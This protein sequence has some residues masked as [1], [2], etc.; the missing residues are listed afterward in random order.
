MEYSLVLSIILYICGCFYMLFGAVLIAANPKS[1][2]NKLFLLLSSSLAIWSFSLSIST[3]APTEEVSAFWRSFSVFGWGMFSSILLHFVLVLTKLK[4]RISK[5]RVH[6]MLYVPAFINIILFGPFGVL[7]DRQYKMVKTA[8]G[9][10]NLAPNYAA[11]IW[12]NAYYI[13][14]SIT[15]LVLLGRWWISIESHTPE[16][17]QATKFL[18]TI[19][20]FFFVEAVVDFLPDI[21]DKQ[22]FPKIPVLFFIIPTIMLFIVLK[23]FG[24]LSKTTRK[25][26][27]FPK[28]K[29]NLAGDRTRLFHTST[30]I[31]LL[32]S[33]ISFLVGYFGQG[34]SLERELLIA[35]ILI[36]FGLVS[37]FIPSI[38]SNQAVQNVIFLVICASGTFY[39]MLVNA[40][41]G[42][43]T[44]WSVYILFLLFTVTLD[45]R[46]LAIIFTA[47]CVVIQ[48]AFWIFYPKIS[49]T[50]DGNEYATRI[51]IIMLSYVAVRYLTNEYNSKV[52]DYKRFAS[53]Q[54]VLER[55]SSSLISISLDN[56]KEKIDELLEMADEILEFSHAYVIEFGTDDEYA[57][58]FS[59]CAKGAESESFPFYSGLKVKTATLPMAAPLIDQDTP[60]M[61]EDISRVSEEEDQGL[62]EFFMPRG[63]LSY[64]AL[65]VNVNSKTAGILVVEY[66]DQLDIE[67]AETRLYFLRFIVN[68]LADA[69]KKTMYEE[70]LYNYA[71]FDETT[72]LANRSMLK[73]QLDQIIHD[74]EGLEKTAILDIE[75]ENLRVIK[76]T[77]GQST[78]EQIMIKSAQVLE[79]LLEGR[80]LLARSGEGGFTIVLPSV[81]STEQV[82]EYAKNVLDSF[83]Q[84]IST[85]TDIE[86]LFVAVGMGISVY[87]DD[88]QDTETLLKNAELAGYEATN[89]P[90]KVVFYT[91]QL[92]KHITENTLLTNSLFKSLQ[93]EELFLEFQPQISCNTG[94]TV[95]VEALLRWTTDKNEKVS[96]DRFVPILE[97]TGLIHNVGRWVLEQALQEH[98]RLIEKG[99]PPLRFSINLSIAQFQDKDF[100]R[101][102]TKIIEES[103]VDPKYIELEITES[104][105]S[106]NPDEVIEKLYK[107]KELGVSIAIDDFGKEY[108]SLNRLNLVPFDRI[109]IDKDIVDLIDVKEKRAPV[110]ESIISLVRAFNA[111]VTA[112]GVEIIEQADF[113]KSIGC[114]EIQGHY[115]SMPLSSEALELFLKM[116]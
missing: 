7:V 89:T 111:S 80:C 64:F 114:D 90:E 100:I 81:I 35:T 40:K 44:V 31:F 105:L 102:F 42:A 38:T 73:K 63:I 48:I 37:R 78:G 92:E 101:D 85:E 75:I 83:S 50:I 52:K 66:N 77:F 109:K 106:D 65:P 99:F 91:E 110:A 96:P 27:S 18:A 79:S 47:F 115:Y 28:I 95:G 45:D 62:K 76:D 55:I 61:C 4:Y 20:L 72:K 57:R 14:F 113:L 33:A 32:G 10:M 41:T 39:F 1:N 87:P 98:N 59:T 15:C 49:V 8:Y 70:R 74:G 21:F 56:A 13:V 16:K 26:Y 93:N 53:E 22:F 23:R 104:L 112:E 97:Q 17:R 107:L 5:S 3:S 94:K 43:L 84:P 54:E 71:Y 103:G 46:I 12:L 60:M 36:F 19:V 34:A 88:G 30:I 67:I 108:S 51:L 58:F 29:K 69:R 2:V 6:A 25:S 9:W 86:A 82:E 68:I 116:E 24:L 11:S